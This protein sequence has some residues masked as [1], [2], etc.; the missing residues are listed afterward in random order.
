ML[1]L[2]RDG[3]TQ[4]AETFDGDRFACGSRLPISGNGPFFVLV[5]RELFIVKARQDYG[6]EASMTSLS[7]SP[8]AALFSS[9]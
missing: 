3:K 7:V 9:Q 8:L 2:K 4:L 1:F 6:S 5:R